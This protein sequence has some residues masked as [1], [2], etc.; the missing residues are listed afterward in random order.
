MPLHRN[1]TTQTPATQVAR[2]FAA[3]DVFVSSGA[4][5]GDGLD[6]PEP[7]CAGDVYELH[8]DAR[9]IDL[10]LDRP[11][12]GQAQRIAQGSGIGGPGDRVELT[13]QLAL[14][15]PD[16]Q[17]VDLLLLRHHPATGLPGQYVLPL[18]PISPRTEYTLLAIEAPARDLQ[19]AD[20]LSLSF[21]RGTRITLASGAQALIETLT[22]G[23]QVLTR[24]HGPQPVRWI[25]RSVLRA[26][27]SF[28]PVV[29]GGGV[30]G[31]EGDLVVGQNHR[32]FLYQRARLAGAARAELL[33][34]ARYLV[35]DDRVYLREGGFAEYYSLVFDQHEII[36]A[37]GIPVESLLITDATVGRLPAELA[38]EL[39][40]RFP[41]LNQSQHFA[42][43]PG[44]DMK[45]AVQEAALRITKPR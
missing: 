36:Y 2:V 28:A 24:D 3:A 29:I 12:G 7:P 39:R 4:N 8:P 34:Q 17:K 32:V 43:E 19:L 40:A 18:S 41:N 13:A 30:L 23:M 38:E 14:M 5:L 6:N 26:R 42:F 20:L 25:G 9:A 45:A 16:G 22:P 33:V 37:E 21:H 15:T 1:T 44:E 11:E 35:E 10:V 27:G 31:N